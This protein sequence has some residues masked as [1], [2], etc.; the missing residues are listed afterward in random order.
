MGLH[1]LPIETIFSELH[2]KTTRLSHAHLNASSKRGLFGALHDED[3]QAYQIH[4]GHTVFVSEDTQP[5][6][7]SNVEGCTSAFTIDGRDSDGWLSPDGWRAGCYLHGLFENDAFRHSIITTLAQ[8]RFAHPPIATR[9]SFNRQNEYDKLAQLLRSYLD[10]P[11][12][13]MLCDI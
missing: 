2:E 10:I 5:Y 1:L 8:R 3:L 6:R 13:K 12:L 9:L 11:A 4:L 7:T